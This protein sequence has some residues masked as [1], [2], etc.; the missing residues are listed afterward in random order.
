MNVIK[1]N[2]TTVPFEE[3][4]IE[5]AVARAF[6]DT[7][8]IDVKSIPTVASAV[9]MMIVTNLKENKNDT[10]TVEQLQDMV[11][12]TALS[13]YYNRNYS[14]YEQKSMDGNSSYS[15]RN[16]TISPEKNINASYAYCYC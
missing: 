5:N 16:I 15:W 3:K 13:Y 8:E 7:G 4:K 2:G 11:V 10:P 1:R 14:D 12:S 6:I 9:T